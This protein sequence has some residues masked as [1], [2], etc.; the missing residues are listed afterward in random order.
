[1]GTSEGLRFGRLSIAGPHGP[2]EV[3]GEERKLPPKA[4]KILW[5]LA[6][7]AG[8]VVTK[9]ELMSTCWPETAVGED[10]L[11]FQISC[12]RSALGDASR[13]PTYIETV[14][15]LGYR[16]RAPEPSTEAHSVAELARPRHLLDRERELLALERSLAR[17]R[18]SEP[19]FIFVG[20]EAGQ[21]KT[22]LIDHFVAGLRDALIGRARC[23]DLSVGNET[24]LPLLDAL[25]AMCRESEGESFVSVLARYAPSWLGR[26]PWATDPQQQRALSSLGVVGPARM[27]RELADALLAAAC[28]RLVVLVLEDIHAADEGSVTDLFA[29]LA[30]RHDAGQLL[31]VTSFRPSELAHSRGR[32]QN[33]RRGLSDRGRALELVLRPLSP[34]ATASYMRARVPRAALHDQGAAWLHARTGGDPTFT[35]RLVDKLVVDWE[36]RGGPLFDVGYTLR[37]AL[38]AVLIE[39]IGERLSKLAP[40]ERQL[41]EASS[42]AGS[43]IEPARLATALGAS[44]QVVTSACERLSTPGYYLERV[45]DLAAAYETPAFAFRCPLL[46]ELVHAQIAAER[47]ESYESM[48]GVKSGSVMVR[49]AWELASGEIAVVQAETRGPA[50]TLAGRPQR[51]RSASGRRRRPR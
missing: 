20:G 16:F 14:H 27:L 38:P 19:Q 9:A 1:M 35:V 11:S 23:V 24:F 48:F 30:S 51:E 18:A 6:A 25:G 39:E 31:V 41:L 2:L 8:C 3:D 32:L 4:L 7:R 28:E 22:A 47:R 12:V 33:V 45:W 43:T 29:L 42:F 44:V 50:A 26:L 10:A 40:E 15:R 17:A 34:A 13:N 37:R 21:G 36:A 46:R 5:T 49:P